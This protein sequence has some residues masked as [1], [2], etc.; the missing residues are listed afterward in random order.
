LSAFGHLNGP[1]TVQAIQNVCQSTVCLLSNGPVDIHWGFGQT[2]SLSILSAGATMFFMQ[3]R[4][5][6]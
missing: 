4:H 2:I 1:R 6:A 5:A 3:V